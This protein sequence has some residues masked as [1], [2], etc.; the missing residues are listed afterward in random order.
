[1]PNAVVVAN[2]LW[3]T[4]QKDFVKIIHQPEDS[5]GLLVQ[6]RFIWV[7]SGIMEEKKNVMKHN[8]VNPNLKI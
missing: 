4:I 6:C 8:K 5:S 7:E 1:M 2:L 3:Y